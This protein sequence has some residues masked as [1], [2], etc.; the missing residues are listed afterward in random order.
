[1]L[2]KQWGISHE[3]LILF[4]MQTFF[5]RAE[6]WVA[7]STEREKLPAAFLAVFPFAVLCSRKIYRRFRRWRTA[8]QRFRK[9]H[10]KLL[11]S[12]AHWKSVSIR[13][14]S[15]STEGFS[16]SGTREPTD[17]LS[18]L[19][20]ATCADAAAE[21]F[22]CFAV[23]LPLRRNE[24][25]SLS[26]CRLARNR[27]FFTHPLENVLA[28]RGRLCRI[29]CNTI[30]RRTWWKKFC[31]IQRRISQFKLFSFQQNNVYIRK[32]SRSFVLFSFKFIFESSVLYSFVFQ[33]RVFK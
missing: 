30:S 12:R 14:K 1:M 2:K 28:I 4:A 15:F 5:L 16:S 3:K 31:W 21:K 29:S 13:E 22:Y 25:L 17:S 9:V 18:V 6:K 24:F 20:E 27:A 26:E 8:Q 7:R 11:S 32:R 10:G 19:H 33:N 23:T